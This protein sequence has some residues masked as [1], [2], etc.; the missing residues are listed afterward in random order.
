ML[1]K[2]AKHDKKLYKKKQQEMKSTIQV[3]L[4]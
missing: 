4:N 2:H 3:L 1:N